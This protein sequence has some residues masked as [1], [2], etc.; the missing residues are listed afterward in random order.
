[1][2]A[3][4]RFIILRNVD[5]MDK[6]GLQEQES[7]LFLTDGTLPCNY[8][9]FRRTWYVARYD[10]L[11]RYLSPELVYESPAATDG[12]PR[13]D[14]YDNQYDELCRKIEKNKAFAAELKNRIA[15]LRRDKFAAVGLDMIY[16]PLHYIARF[17]PLRFV[18]L[19]KIR[20]M[21]SYGDEIVLANSRYTTAV[22]NTRIWVMQKITVLLDVRIRCY[23]EMARQ[24]AE[25]ADNSPWVPVPAWYSQTIT[26]Y[27]DIAGLPRSIA[28]NF[29]TSDGEIPAT[30]HFYTGAENGAFFGWYL[31]IDSNGNSGNNENDSGGDSFDFF[32]DPKK[33][34]AAIYARRGK[35]PEQSR[36]KINCTLYVNPARTGA[37]ERGIIE[38][39]IA[40]F[41]RTDQ[42]GIDISIT[43]GGTKRT[44]ETSGMVFEIRESPPRHGST[45]IFRG[46]EY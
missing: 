7:V 43:C 4:S 31:S 30:L 37:L 25:R 18:D 35:T 16:L 10:E 22:S 29:I 9:A 27:W 39:C 12:G 34:A 11:D 8:P 41:Y 24:Y 46:Q 36:I 33:S 23:E 21:T 45:L 13:D 5:E 15:G 1:M 40:P 32:L 2:A 20:T 6:V 17:T 3:S 28:G 19:P 14:Q 26:G 44:K 38:K 42:E